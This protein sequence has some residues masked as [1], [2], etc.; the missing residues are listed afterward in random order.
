MPSAPP[1]RRLLRALRWAALGLGAVLLAACG[2]LYRPDLPRA[3]LEARWAAPPSQ[4]VQVAGLRLHIRDT[5]PRQAHPVIM[6]H[7]FGSSLHA[8]DGLAAELEAGWRIIRLDLPGFGLTGPE[9]S[10]DYSDARAHAVIAA[11]MDHLGIRRATILGSSMG[12]RIAWSFAAAEPARVARLVLLAPDGFASL[13]REYDRPSRVPLLLR[14]LPYTMPDFLLRGGL[15]PAYG[16]SGALTPE[17]F[18]RY[19]DMLLAPGIRQAIVDRTAQH[20]LH[21]PEPLLAGIMAPTLLLWGERDRM[22]P[23]SHA[24]DYLRIMPHARAVVLPGIGHVPMEEAPAAVAE[25]VRSFLREPAMAM[26]EVPR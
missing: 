21:P 5:G 15:A 20:V 12:G 22:I 1:A 17:L 2:V 19:R 9:P 25:A 8:W 26:C 10:G 11:L 6:L 16:D 23:A 3:E 18:A 13:G 7:G 4:F 24:E 14:A